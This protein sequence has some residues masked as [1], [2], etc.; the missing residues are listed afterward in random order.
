MAVRDGFI[1][2]AYELSRREAELVRAMLK[3]SYQAACQHE[4]DPG[5]LAEKTNNAKKNK[6]L[7][8]RAKAICKECPVRIECLDHAMRMPERG[9]IWGGMNDGE[10]DVLVK[11]LRKM[12]PGMYA[13]Y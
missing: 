8:L 2:K 3:W 6:E 11:K 5:F 12:N 13:E 7:E 4:P 10:R 1:D 9:G